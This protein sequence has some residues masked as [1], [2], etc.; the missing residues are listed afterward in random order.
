MRGKQM[1]CE[2]CYTSFM[3]SNPIRMA[4]CEKCRRWICY[5]CTNA[6]LRGCGLGSVADFNHFVQHKAD[7]VM[8][9]GCMCPFCGP[10]V[11]G[12]GRKSYF[13]LPPATL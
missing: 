8:L 3:E 4:K 7:E 12:K 6:D 5:R 13:L 11:K 1:K 2:I 9:K 10:H